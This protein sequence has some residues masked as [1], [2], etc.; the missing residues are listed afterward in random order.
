MALLTDYESNQPT[1]GLE[2]DLEMKKALNQPVT[3]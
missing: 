2:M 1:E 3:T